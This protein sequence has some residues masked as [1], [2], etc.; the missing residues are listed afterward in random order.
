MTLPQPELSF[1]E[2]NLLLC[3]KRSPGVS[4]DTLVEVAGSRPRAASSLKNLM[5]RGLVSR[6][7]STNDLEASNIARAATWSY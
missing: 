3:I 4:V 7:E 2:E 6:S 1:V 5:E